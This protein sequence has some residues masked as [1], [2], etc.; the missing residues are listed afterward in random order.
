MFSEIIIYF[1]GISCEFLVNLYCHRQ[2]VVN[3]HVQNEP[4]WVLFDLCK[5]ENIFVLFR[6]ILLILDQKMPRQ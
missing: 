3:T 1:T 4:T 5:K 2:A 6:H